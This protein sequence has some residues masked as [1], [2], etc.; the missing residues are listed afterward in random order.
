MQKHTF[1]VW[2][3]FTDT[4]VQQTADSALAKLIQPYD[5]FLVLDVEGTCEQ[6]SGFDYPNEII[7][8]VHSCLD[9]L[10]LSG[11]DLK[12]IPCVSY[13]MEGQAKTWTGG[14]WRIP[15]FCTTFMEANPHQ[16]LRRAYRNNSGH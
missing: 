4:Q 15:Q 16:I 13:E 10:F 2:N 6:G 5:V 12:G 11:V 3:S 9:E 8:W 1:H 14:H 7:V